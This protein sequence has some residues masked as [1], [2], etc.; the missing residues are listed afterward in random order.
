MRQ[1]KWLTGHLIVNME[2]KRQSVTK[3]SKKKKLVL[4]TKNERKN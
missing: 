4:K 2:K 1:G 3:L